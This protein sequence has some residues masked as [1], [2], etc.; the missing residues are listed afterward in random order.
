[1]PL[2]LMASGADRIVDPEASGRFAV[3]APKGKLDL[4]LWDGLYHEMFN[5]PERE[6]VFARMEAWLEERVSPAGRG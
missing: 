6:M 3:R 2:L 5:E 1:V 4:V